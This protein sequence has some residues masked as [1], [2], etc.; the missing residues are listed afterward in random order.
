MYYQ[1][2]E[3]N[4]AAMQPMRALADATR[5]FYSNPLNPW[6]QTLSGPVD[7][8]NG[9]TVRKADTPLRQAGF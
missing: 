9:R 8:C 6:S 4:H 7:G 1:F 3:L 5:L 2:Y